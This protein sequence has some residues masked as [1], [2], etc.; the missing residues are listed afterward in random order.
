[1]LLVDIGNTRVKSAWYEYGALAAWPSIATRG[2]AVF[3]AWPVEH[4]PAAPARVLVSNV[5]GS[6]V[7]GHLAE[8][9]HAQWGIEAE[10]VRPQRSRCGM[11]TRYREPLRLGVDRWLAALAAWHDEDGAV[12]VIDV[13]TALTADIVTADGKHLGGLIAPGPELMRESLTRGTADL[14]CDALA[15]V[16]GFADNTADAIS[17]GCTLATGGLLA[18]V[19]TRLRDVPGCAEAAWY[20]TGGGA[21]YLLP[22][23]DWPCAQVPDLVLRGLALIAEEDA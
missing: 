21:A 15:D 22:Y 8:F 1:M 5:A 20:L 6:G 16:A 9:V 19:H 18:A 14:A 7:A 12:C 3:A 11:H 23:I 10:F 13:G 17:L 4:L 2:E